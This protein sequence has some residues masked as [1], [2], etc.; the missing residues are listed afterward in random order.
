MSFSGG[1]DFIRS[2]LTVPSINLIKDL[3]CWEL[4][5]NWI[6]T[7]GNA[8][9]YLKIGIKSSQLQDLKFEKQNNPLLR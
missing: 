6:P 8:G 2:S 4:I 7:G 9:F 3:H 5:F 1:Y